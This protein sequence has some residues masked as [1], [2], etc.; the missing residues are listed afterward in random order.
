MS[1]PTLVEMI[2][3]I[4]LMGTVIGTWVKMSVN[5]AKH[6]TELMSHKEQIAAIRRE[7]ERDREK[8]SQSLVNLSEKIDQMP[9]RIL[10]LMNSVNKTAGIP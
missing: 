8:H 4:T 7:Q 3:I 10:D 1:S 9:Q 6:D 2:S 5:N